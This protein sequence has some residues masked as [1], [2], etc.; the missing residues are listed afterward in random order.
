MSIA[1]AE[2]TDPFESVYTFIRSS[3]ENVHIASARLRAWCLQQDTQG[4]LERLR[5]P[6]PANFVSE[7]LAENI[8]SIPHVQQLQWA[9][10]HNLTD[11]EPIILAEGGTCTTDGNP[12]TMLVDGH[13]RAFIAYQ[14]GCR[15]V[16]CWALSPKQWQPFRIEGRHQFSKRELADYP[17]IKPLIDRWSDAAAE[18]N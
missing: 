4:K 16:I 12:N 2:M 11:W 1:A 9:L 6:I 14:A 18:R 15:F 5:W 10:P 17:I 13:H 3:G 8:I 7:C